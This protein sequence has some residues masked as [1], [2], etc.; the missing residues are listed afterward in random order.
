[1]TFRVDLAAA[2]A[3]GHAP[4]RRTLRPRPFWLNPLEEGSDLMDLLGYASG[5]H[6]EP[7]MGEGRCIDAQDPD[8]WFPKHGAPDDRASAA[9]RV[10]A[11]CPVALTCLNYAMARPYLQGIWGGTTHRERRK[12]H[13]KA[14]A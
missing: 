1:V 3:L 11:V 5:P 2:D 14:P 13:R 7:W 4:I 9:I 6:I 12:Q 10:C 8:A